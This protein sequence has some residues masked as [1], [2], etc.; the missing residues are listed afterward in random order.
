MH[1]SMLSGTKLQRQLEINVFRENFGLLASY[2]MFNANYTAWELNFSSFSTIFYYITKI[3]LSLVNNYPN[4]TQ[5]T[6]SI[7]NL[8]KMI[9]SICI[10]YCII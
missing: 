8:A 1:L 10:I 3:V 5:A 4:I 6:I 2:L 7:F 9:T